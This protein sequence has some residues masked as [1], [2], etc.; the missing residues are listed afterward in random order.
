MTSGR[1]L[2]NILY[3][4]YVDDEAAGLLE[5]KYAKMGC[6]LHGVLLLMRCVCC[7]C[8]WCCCWLS[9]MTQN[10]DDSQAGMPYQMIHFDAAVLIVLLLQAARIVSEKRQM[11][12]VQIY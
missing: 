8:W 7:C 9:H 10:G 3:D 1:A 12:V 2:G 11:T 5:Y 4:A 6:L